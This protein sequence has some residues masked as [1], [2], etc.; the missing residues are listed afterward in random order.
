MDD[1]LSDLQGIDDF[2]ADFKK[3]LYDRTGWQE[4]P[5]EHQGSY[6]DRLEKDWEVSDLL[7]RNEEFASDI[8]K[9]KAKYD[10]YKWNVDDF[11]GHDEMITKDP[12]RK[13]FYLDVQEI[14]NKIRYPGFWERG[15]WRLVLS[16][17]NK[18]SIYVRDTKLIR[19]RKHKDHVDIQIYGDVTVPELRAYVPRIRKLIENTEN[20]KTHASIRKK[21]SLAMHLA[22]YDLRK[23]GKSYRQISKHLGDDKIGYSDISKYMELIQKQ[24]AGMYA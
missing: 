8:Q 12:A 10:K 15:L 19:M 24:I 21:S 9:L 7:I 23:Q 13:Q 17:S 6:E 18:D 4:L 16:K 1:G 14:A 20:R 22:I 3:S 11:S 2:I 5:I